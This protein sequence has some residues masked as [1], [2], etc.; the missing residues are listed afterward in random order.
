MARLLAVHLTGIA[1]LAGIVAFS[2]ET[3]GPDMPVLN[4]WLVIGLT[5]VYAGYSRSCCCGFGP[6]PRASAATTGR[7]RW[8]AVW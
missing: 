1:V 7:W 5:A 8:A 4:H 3:V 6:A 2:L